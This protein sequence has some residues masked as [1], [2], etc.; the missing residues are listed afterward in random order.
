MLNDIVLISLG[1][2]ADALRASKKVKENDNQDRVLTIELKRMT[3]NYRSISKYIAD[4]AMILKL[5]GER[6]R[7]HKTID[8]LSPKYD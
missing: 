3:D 4:T 5:L 2:E 8:I 1:N 7:I 6:I